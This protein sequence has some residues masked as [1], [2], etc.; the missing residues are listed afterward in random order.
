M[1][2]GSCF[3]AEHSENKWLCVHLKFVLNIMGQMRGNIILIQVVLEGMLF[4]VWWHYV[5]NL[6]VNNEQVNTQ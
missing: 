2:N 3:D 5:K 1:D 6:N 4:W